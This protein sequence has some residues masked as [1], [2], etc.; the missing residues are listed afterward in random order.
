MAPA[1]T[2]AAVPIVP[3]VPDT[4][5]EQLP[6]LLA[7]GVGVTVLSRLYN[8]R[9]PFPTVTL[10]DPFPWCFM[11][12][13]CV[14][15]ANAIYRNTVVE[16]HGSA[17]DFAALGAIAVAA[18]AFARALTSS[19]SYSCGLLCSIDCDSSM[20]ASS[21]SGSVARRDTAACVCVRCNECVDSSRGKVYATAIVNDSIE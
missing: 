10:T 7:V 20:V 15:V 1:P 8:K 2:P 4:L 3:V 9:P 17:D 11:A 6:M 21:S 19:S 14:M 13:G 16:A 5:L 18:G 12:A